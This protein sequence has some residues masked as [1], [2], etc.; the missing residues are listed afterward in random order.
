MKHMT[1]R[2]KAPTF[3]V[4]YLDGSETEERLLPFQQIAYE[5]ETG[6]P[7]FSQDEGARMEKVYRLAWYASGKPSAFDEWVRSLEAVS[8]VED[9]DGADNDETEDGSDPSS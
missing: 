5:K 1:A 2:A 8:M 3:I 9:E 6:E 7:L 4:Y